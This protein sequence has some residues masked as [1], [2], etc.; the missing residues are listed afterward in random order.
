MACSTC[1]R[2]MVWN[3][4]DSNQIFY[5]YNCSTQQLQSSL[6]GAGQFYSV[7]GCPDNGA[8]ASSNEVYFE[9]GGTGYINYN[10]ILLNPCDQDYPEPSITP[11]LFPTRTPNLTPTNTTTPTITP[12]V[13]R[14]PNAT[15]TTTPIIC[16]SGVTTTK[17]VYYTD[18]C[19]NFV[20][21]SLVVGTTVV[22]NYNQP[23]NG[24]TKLNVPATTSCPTPTP[25]KT[26]TPTPTNTPT[27]TNTPTTSVTPNTTPTPTPTVSVSKVLSLKND[28]DVITLFDMGVLC[29]P[30]QMPSNQYSNDG[31]LSLNVTGGTSPYSFYWA[32]GQRTR[33][34]VGIPE[35]S[36][37]VTVVDYYGDYSSTTVCNLFAPSQTPTQT[38]TPTP[39]LTPSPVWGDLCLT[40]VD[41]ATSYGPIQ[42]TPYSN[43]N[44]KPNWTGTYQGSLLLIQWSS[45][46]ARWAISGLPFTTGIPVSYNQTNIPTGIWGLLGS[47]GKPKITTV[48]GTCPGYIP[49][50]ISIG[51]DNATC[52]GFKNCDGSISIYAFNGIPP[53]SY[54]IDNGLTYQSSGI[55]NGLCANNYTVIVQDSN[56]TIVN[57][58]VVPVGADNNPVNYNI[59]AQLLNN[60]SYSPGNQVASWKVNITPPIP[61]G[62]TVNFQLKV[63][64]TQKNNG[65]GSGT[66]V[67]NTIVR[68]NGVTVA[69]PATTNS[70][71]Q[72]LLR[73]NCSPFSTVT[74]S[75]TQVYNLTMGYGD[76][77][78]G[79]SQSLLTITSGV[80]GSN[81]CITMVEQ[82]ILVSTFA[83]SL[84]GKASCGQTVNNPAGQGVVGHQLSSATSTNPIS[85]RTLTGTTSCNAGQIGVFG[86]TSLQTLYTQASPG[87]VDGATVYTNS[88][89]NSSYL[90][91]NNLVFRNPNNVSSNVYVISSGQMIL[92]GPNGSPC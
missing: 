34:L 72:T 1:I 11:T 70:A 78:T 87:F 39:T 25:T 2:W 63:N 5:S 53:Y 84:S 17:N 65:P 46:S 75:T 18:C 47:S 12:T 58:G 22:F 55:F 40:Y 15:P 57:G 27:L 4:S 81:G 43:A 10:G 19:G 45:A 28:C 59:S 62:V 9:N 68:K 82:T 7:C 50:S 16:G 41:G 38:I 64:A 6:I 66:T 54:S 3:E 52:S 86:T 36:Y 29:N 71:N 30:I 91:P 44:G 13:T 21:A 67:N 61:T 77:I 24:I 89:L 8:Y 31:V 48:I 20:S 14:T 56:G 92:V 33:T 88:S 83:A 60:V 42:F 23:Y 90:A 32:N 80:T 85:L 35:G 74:T 73:P 76:T 51:K 26:Q 37:E 69:A 49:L 79:T